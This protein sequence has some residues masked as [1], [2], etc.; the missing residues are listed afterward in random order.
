MEVI[1]TH[2]GTLPILGVCLGMQALG[3]LTGARLYNR[4]EVIHGQGC[5]LH[6]TSDATGVLLSG[7][8]RLEV[9]MYHSW[10]IDP[11]SLPPRWNLTATAYAEG[12]PMVIEDLNSAA[13]GV[14]FHPESILTPQG[15]E[16]LENWVRWSREWLQGR[17]KTPE[18][19]S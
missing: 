6:L 3:E 13:F 10:A 2:L 12:A 5:P 18:I 4:G 11:S 19:H 8:D 15:R 17:A 7:L 9:G 1:R 16:L 14:Q